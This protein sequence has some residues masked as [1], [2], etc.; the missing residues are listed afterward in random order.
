MTRPSS[1]VTHTSPGESSHQH[2][3]V[4][5][6]FHDRPSRDSCGQHEGGATVPQVMQPEPVQVGSLAQF[7]QRRLMLRGSTGVPTAGT[8]LS[9]PGS[10]LGE[11]PPG[12]STPSQLDGTA[13][14]S[15]S[16]LVPQEATDSRLPRL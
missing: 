3:R 6:H 9:A 4:T 2:R 1:T 15:G 7:I 12:A 13:D 8:A 5:E 11:A 10:G 14:R 16:H